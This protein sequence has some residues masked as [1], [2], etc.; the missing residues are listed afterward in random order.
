MTKLSII[1]CVFMGTVMLVYC[2]GLMG[3]Y[4][5]QRKKREIPR[6]TKTRAIRETDSE[7][8]YKPYFLDV[9]PGAKDFKCDVP[10]LEDTFPTQY[11]ASREE[12]LERMT[13]LI[14][15]YK[16]REE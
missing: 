3:K 6:P 11:G 1:L 2:G 16:A 8:K 5:R 14:D 12:A 7:W 9:L 15:K 13:V 4:S 10:G